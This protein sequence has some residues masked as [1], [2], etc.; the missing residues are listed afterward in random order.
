[1]KV[2]LVGLP[3]ALFEPA[4]LL[5]LRLLRLLRGLRPRLVHVTEVW[6]SAQIAA[7]L[8]GVPRIV[9]THHTPGLPRTDNGFGRLW[10]R[11][12]SWLRVRASCALSSK[13]AP[14]AWAS[15]TES[16]SPARATTSRT[17]S[18]RSTSSRC[19]RTL[20]AFVWR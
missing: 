11:P 20:R 1:E 13:R 18:R 10:L 15:P 6:P 8:A 7:R 4:P 12:G 5:T 14:S 3:P 9:V 17:Y 2:R 16:S 19:R